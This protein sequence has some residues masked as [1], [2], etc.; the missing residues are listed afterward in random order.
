MTDTRSTTQPAPATE[1]SI[2]PKNIKAWI[3]GGVV[4]LVLIAL[5]GGY[6]GLVT[7]DTAVQEAAGN[8]ATLYQR[9]ADLIPN[10]VKTVQAAGFQ[11][12]D[13][14]REVIE[15]RASATK[16][17]IDPSKATPAQLAAMTAAQGQLAAALGKLMVVQE[18]YPQLKS[19]QNF[20]ALQS[21]IEG[22]ENR[23]SVGRQRYNRAVRDYKVSTQ[24]FPTNI[25][26][27]LFGHYSPNQYS[28]F[29]EKAGAD[30]APSVNFDSPAKR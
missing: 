4:A 10:L 7:R 14:L 26:N 11:E 5:W 1:P 16:V 28:M 23:I 15:A 20:I 19:N 29:V 3:L 8:V 30:V 18:Q 12:R 13:T 22:T 24:T 17:T 25:S 21:Q 2:W 9:R 27:M 6:N